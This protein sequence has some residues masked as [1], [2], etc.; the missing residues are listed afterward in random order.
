MLQQQSANSPPPKAYNH[1]AG[2]NG[3][4]KKYSY[5]GPE[6]M[7]GGHH[8]VNKSVNY[9]LGQS[10]LIPDSQHLPK[11]DRLPHRSIDKNNYQSQVMLPYNQNEYP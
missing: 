4:Q 6:Y 10:I 3:A 5:G 7:N 8:A 9:S 2:K 11:V 1:Y